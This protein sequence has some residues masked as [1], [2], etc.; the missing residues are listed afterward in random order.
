[1]KEMLDILTRESENIENVYLYEEA[2]HW[3]AYERSAQFVNTLLTGL[4]EMKRFVDNLYEI[5]IDRVEVDLSSII[6]YPII[7]CSDSELVID[8][9]LANAS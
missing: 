9:S 4:V 6:D 5:A 2:G 7:L 8:C 1:M 3:Y